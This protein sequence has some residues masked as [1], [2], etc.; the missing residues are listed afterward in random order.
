MLSNALHHCWSRKQEDPQWTRLLAIGDL[1]GIEG[2][3]WSWPSYLGPILGFKLFSVMSGSAGLEGTIPRTV[4]SAD[5]K[6]AL[7]RVVRVP[8]F[9]SNPHELVI[10]GQAYYRK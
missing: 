6:T 9:C 10:L 7:E 1:S 8:A 4:M 5:L 3:S 2:A